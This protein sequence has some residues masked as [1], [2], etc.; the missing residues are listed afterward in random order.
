MGLT[1]DLARLQV[2]INAWVRQT[3]PEVRT[4]IQTQ[5]A[6]RAK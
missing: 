5:L 2:F 6:G 1:A 4:M 3:D